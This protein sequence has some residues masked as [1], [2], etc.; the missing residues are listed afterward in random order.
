MLRWCTFILKLMQSLDSILA[1]KST[2]VYGSTVGWTNTYINVGTCDC[3]TTLKL[4]V[5]K[6]NDAALTLQLDVLFL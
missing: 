4:R 1:L 2:L 6:E 3:K 5:L